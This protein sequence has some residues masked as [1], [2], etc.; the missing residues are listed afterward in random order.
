[1]N[2]KLMVVG[3]CLFLGAC[4][5]GNKHEYSGISP[6]VSMPSTRSVALGVLD[7]RDYVVNGSKRES[8]VGIS[9]GGFGNPFDITTAS[10]KALADDFRATIVEVLKRNGVNVREISLR[11]SR[12]EGTGRELL[13]KLGQE[14]AVLLAV[15]EWKSDTYTSTGLQYNVEMTVYD[16]SGKL[17]GDKRLQGNDNLGG[18]LINPPGHAREAVPIAYRKKIEELLNA[19]EIR[20]ALQ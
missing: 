6:D 9:R 10:D 12:E 1:M 15:R 19:P 20:R 16:L 18:D 2:V 14:R 5:I 11:P 3:S 7:Q 17:L 4:A 13:I 8:F